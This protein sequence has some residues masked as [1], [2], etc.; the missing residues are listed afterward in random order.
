MQLSQLIQDG[1]LKPGDQLPSE[2]DLADQLGVGRSTVREAKRALVS[3]GLI[4]SEGKRGTFVST[5][6][7]G[8]VEIA[9]LRERLSAG[10]LTDI[11][12][13]RRIIEVAVTGLAARRRTAKDIRKLESL[14][15]QIEQEWR[16]NGTWTAGLG[17]HVA[18]V[19]ASH[20]EV[21][22]SIYSLLAKFVDLHHSPYYRG[23]TDAREEIEG[24]R[25]L[26]EA[27]K[28]GDAEAAADAMRHHIDT[29]EARRQRV[30]DENPG[31]ESEH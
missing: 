13:A 21:L 8:D 16:R 24:H 18:V 20:N 5:R 7:T 30:I 11:Y 12:E 3:M 19:A 1:H 2:P 4:H 28:S 29:V 17:F 6:P 25:L 26:L 14:L 22:T 31:G 10:V 23:I 9:E 27:I 15:R